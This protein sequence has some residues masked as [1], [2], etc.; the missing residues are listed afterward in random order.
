MKNGDKV[1]VIK[2]AKGKALIVCMD[3]TKF[4]LELD[5]SIEVKDGDILT[6]HFSK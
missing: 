4:N 5:K 1:Q 3:G 6:I 2:A